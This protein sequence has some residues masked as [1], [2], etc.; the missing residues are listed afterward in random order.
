MFLNEW[1]LSQ[2]PKNRCHA[3]D[4]PGTMFKRNGSRMNSQWI[5]M[6]C[7]ELKGYKTSGRI[8]YTQGLVALELSQVT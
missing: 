6:D 7:A 2:T 4:T 5:T 1:C 8:K 3:L